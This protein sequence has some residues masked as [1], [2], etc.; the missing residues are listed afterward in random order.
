MSSEFCI[1]K[2]IEYEL[3]EELWSIVKAYAGIFDGTRDFGIKLNFK[4]ISKN[5]GKN[6][7][8]SYFPEESYFHPKKLPKNIKLK[9]VNGCLRFIHNKQ[10]I[11]YNKLAIKLIKSFIIKN[12]KMTPKTWLLLNEYC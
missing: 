5:I 10:E 3:P 7:L 9:M 8:V 4:K 11:T 12:N 6:I 1:R 2:K